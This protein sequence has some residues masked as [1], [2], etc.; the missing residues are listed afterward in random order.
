MNKKNKTLSK[1]IDQL[2]D[3]INQARTDIDSL[4]N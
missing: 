2:N 1:E 3:T 4:L